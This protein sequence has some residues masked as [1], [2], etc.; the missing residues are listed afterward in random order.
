MVSNIYTH[1]HFFKFSWTHGNK[2]HQE[3]IYNI[4][5]NGNNWDIKDGFMNE[6]Y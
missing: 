1:T 6:G 3:P 4:E 5:N 2:L